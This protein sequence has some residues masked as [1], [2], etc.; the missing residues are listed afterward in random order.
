MTFVQKPVE[1]YRLWPDG[2]WDKVS[3]C[4]EMPRQME[5]NIEFIESRAVER[6]WLDLLDESNKPVQIGLYMLSIYGVT[7][8]QE[9]E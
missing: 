7:N 9:H 2:R 4:I 6:A 3:I 5:D 8:K 1:C